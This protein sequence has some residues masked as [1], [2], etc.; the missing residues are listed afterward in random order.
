MLAV[1][2]VSIL[3]YCLIVSLKNVKKRTECIISAMLARSIEKITQTSS[4]YPKF[5]PYVNKKEHRI[6]AQNGNVNE[7]QLL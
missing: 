1:F 5:Y 6:Q 2:G 7:L 4:N 3:Q